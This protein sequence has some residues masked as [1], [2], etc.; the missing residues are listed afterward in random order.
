MFTTLKSN[1]FNYES[2][3]RF[4]CSGK[5]EPHLLQEYA[6]EVV[7]T[8][9]CMYLNPAAMPVQ[10]PACFLKEVLISLSSVVKCWL[11]LR[12]LIS[13]IVTT[14][15]IQ[16]PRQILHNLIFHIIVEDHYHETGRSIRW[17]EVT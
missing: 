6:R 5:R 4:S 12:V 14:L 17:L 7:K 3:N 11:L 15:Q 8:L 9:S 16:R 13:P 10:P 1:L 2:T